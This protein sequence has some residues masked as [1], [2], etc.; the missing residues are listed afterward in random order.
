MS[1]L[2][3]GIVGLNEGNGHP[4]SYSAIFNGYDPSALDALCPFDL[5]K[6]YLPSEHRNEVFVDDAKVT[7]IWTQDQSLSKQIAKVSRIPVVVKSLQ[8]MVGEVDGVILARDDSENNLSHA[9]PFLE[10]GLPIFIDKQLA[11]TE[12]EFQAILSF[13]GPDYPILSGSGAR[14]SRKLEHVS[15]VVPK[16]SV[17][18]IHG[19]CRQNWI[20]YGHHVFEPIV[21]LF[22]TDIVEIRCLRL[23]PDHQ[24]VQIRYESDLM[25][26]LEFISSIHL[27]IQFTCFS[28]EE[29]P[30]IVRFDDFF[31]SYRNMLITF[32]NFVRDGVRPFPYEE[33]IAVARIVLAGKLS[34]E[35][36]GRWLDPDNLRA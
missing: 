30:L 25:V 10:A 18:S 14:Y 3:F 2:S 33:M 31:Q 28:T 26:S 16:L 7:H 4:Y 22:G 34:E 23:N 1:K 12:H 5:I 32:T 13:L 17:R 24:M 11:T 35:R 8:D 27:P 20:R 36:S 21:S 29:P 6:Q 19:M 9:E 15:G